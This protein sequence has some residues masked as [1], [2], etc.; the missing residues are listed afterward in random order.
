M[1]TVN[2]QLRKAL[3][4]LVLLALTGHVTADSLFQEQGFHALV[5]DQRAWRP[6]DNL[7]VVITEIAS[8]SATANTE[9][10]KDGSVYGKVR[11]RDDN[12]DIGG[13]LGEEFNGTG[14]IER[15]GRMIAQLT[16][17][18]L[19]VEP[20]GDLRVKGSQEITVNNE[21]QWIALEGRVRGQDIRTDN[22]VLSSRVSDARIEYTGKG[23]LAE[24]QRP[25]ILTRFLS[26]LR[27]L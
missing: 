15:S 25:G 11:T 7:T 3:A 1:R 10:K 23:I 8:V 2:M 16:V 26:W 9:T 27:L 12:I 14:R 4:A 17:T 18:V 20:N 22:T 13:G 5:A 6:G 19:G 24:K 21:R